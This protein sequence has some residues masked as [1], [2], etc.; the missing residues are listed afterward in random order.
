MYGN[1]EVTSGGHALKY[2][3]P[4]STHPN[5][6]PLCLIAHTNSGCA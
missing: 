3:H 5:T 1:D 6:P 4:I 2:H